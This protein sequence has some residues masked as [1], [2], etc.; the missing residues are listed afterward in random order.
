VQIESETRH[1]ASTSM[2]SLTICVRVMSPERH[3]WKRAVHAAAVTLR[4]P[5][6][7]AGH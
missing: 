4:T 6:S 1:R 3:H 7:P 5:P 2:Y